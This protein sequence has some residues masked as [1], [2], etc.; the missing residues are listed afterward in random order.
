VIAPGSYTVQ[1]AGAAHV[2]L[3]SDFDGATRTPFDTRGV[4]AITDGLLK[5][6]LDQGA[7]AR[8]MGGNMRDFLLQQLPSS[9]PT[10][11]AGR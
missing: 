5:A 11:R 4:A 2:A 3:G 1:V 9:S 7:V 8:V 6:G 10:L